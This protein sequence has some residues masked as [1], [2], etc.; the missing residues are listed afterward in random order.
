ME[1]QAV[2][3][4]RVKPPGAY[5]LRRGAWYPVLENNGDGS[6]VVLDLS[7]RIVVIPCRNLQIRGDHPTCFSVVIKRPEDPNPAR[8]TAQDLGLEYAVCPLSHTR[9][10]LSGHPEFLECPKCGYEFPVAWDEHC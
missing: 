1:R 5:S 6:E 7:H 8:G 10:R 2:G 3:W 9:V 4:A